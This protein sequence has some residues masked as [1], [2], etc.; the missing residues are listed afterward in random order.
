MVREEFE[1]WN[2]VTGSQLVIVEGPELEG[3]ITNRA[4]ALAAANQGLNPV[5]L[6]DENLFFESEGIPADSGVLAFA[7]PLTTNNPAAPLVGFLA[8]QP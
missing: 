4:E 3:S 5:V 6:D 8:G 1:D 2:Q 7:A